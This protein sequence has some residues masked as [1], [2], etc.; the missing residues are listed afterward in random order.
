VGTFCRNI[1]K[2]QKRTASEKDLSLSRGLAFR[3][4]NYSSPGFRI[5]RVKVQITIDPRDC[6]TYIILLLSLFRT[7]RE[8]VSFVLECTYYSH[9][10]LYCN[11]VV[12]PDVYTSG[13]LSRPPRSG[14]DHD[15]EGEDET[16]Y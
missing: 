7:L 8:E 6:V 16:V 2:N 15:S 12:W 4:R 14:F 10:I 3:S 13:R 9:I 11:D 1:S 5:T